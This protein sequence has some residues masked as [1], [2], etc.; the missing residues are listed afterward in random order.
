MKQFT[1]VALLLIG[2]TSAISKSVRHTGKFEQNLVSMGMSSTSGSSAEDVEE[3]DDYQALQIR[4]IEEKKENFHGYHPW[5]NG[6]EGSSHMNVEW[7]SPYERVTPTAFTGDER[8]TFTAKMI[9]EYALE[10]H[11]EKTGKPN[12]HFFITRAQAQKIGSEVVEQHLA[13]KGPKKDDY[14]KQNFDETW[15]HYDE[16]KSGVLDALEANSFMRQLCRK[17]KEIDLQ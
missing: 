10:G 17:E 12:G 3:D 9:E 6:F 15:D 1:A 8:D 7:R 13:F 14:M 4:G 16:S 2:S 11:D 5:Y